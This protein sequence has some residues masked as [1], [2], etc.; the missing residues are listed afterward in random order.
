M[1]KMEHNKTLNE[2]MKMTQ[3]NGQTLSDVEQKE[4]EIKSA[5]EIA[6][7]GGVAVS[8]DAPGKRPENEKKIELIDLEKYLKELKFEKKQEMTPTS[9]V[10]IIVYD[11]LTRGAFFKH[12]L[13]VRT[14]TDC[15]NILREGVYQLERTENLRAMVN[16]MTAIV[17]DE[18]AKL[19]AALKSGKR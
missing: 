9:Q 1:T 16:M 7:D 10:L 6:K 14:F 13:N 5:A 15:M 17:S 19:F 4:G 3:V 11:P 12:G 2:E 18:C 8:A